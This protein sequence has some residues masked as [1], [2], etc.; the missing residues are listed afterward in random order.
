VHKPPPATQRISQS[1]MQATPFP[2]M[3]DTLWLCV[4]PTDWQPSAS[5]A[6]LLQPSCRCGSPQ[7]IP[8]LSPS[9]C[10][11]A[12]L[13]DSHGKIAT[14]IELISTLRGSITLSY[15]CQRCMVQDVSVVQSARAITRR[16]NNA[17]RYCRI[18][19]SLLPLGSL[20]KPSAK[21][22]VGL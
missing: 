2:V 22:A 1:Y 17:Y 13:S 15:H 14:S 21:L 12:E 6:W 16:R 11:I 10:N 7:T 18:R 8:Q 9:L 4:L 19:S 3:E 5:F 20:P